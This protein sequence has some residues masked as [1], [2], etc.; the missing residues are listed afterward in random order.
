MYFKYHCG[1]FIE[2]NK[3]D[4]KAKVKFFLGADLKEYQKLYYK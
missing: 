4:K 3:V 1:L 2:S